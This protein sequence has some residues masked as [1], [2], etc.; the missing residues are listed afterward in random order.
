VP[1]APTA[2]SGDNS[3]NACS[4]GTE[5]GETIYIGPVAAVTG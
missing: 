4:V 5:T 2:T 3:P 1:A